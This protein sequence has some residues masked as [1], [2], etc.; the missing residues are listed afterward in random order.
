[1]LEEELKAL[2]EVRSGA[3][4]SIYMPADEV[5][6]EKRKN[7]I[8]LKNLLRD[9][10]NALLQQDLRPAAA[11]D[12]LKRAQVLVAD[13]AFWRKQSS[14]IAI[15]LNPQWFR[16]YSLPLE[17]K[18]EVVVS[19]RFH[20]KPILP[21]LTADYGFFVLALS[22][23][24]IGFFE[25]TPYDIREIALQNIPLSLDEALKYDDPERQLQFHTGTSGASG[26]D[27]RSAMFH[28]Q[29]DDSKDDI[30]RFFR[31]V[32]KGLQPLLAKEQKPLLLAGVEYLHA[33]YKSAN[34]YSKLLES[35]I[36]GNIDKFS[37][38]QLH[39]KSWNIARVHFRKEREEEFS[40]YRDLRDTR[41]ATGD[42]K[43]IVPASFEGRIDTLFVAAGSRQWGSFDA[44]KRSLMLHSEQEPGD[45][46]LTDFAAAHAYMKGGRVY[47]VKPEEFP[48]PLLCAAIF[49]Y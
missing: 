28:G 29:A 15:F 47:V 6:K 44:E 7:P 9:A 10:E 13:S 11:K 1:M 33:I 42:I 20:I 8:R 24:K 49:R 16:T 22:Q 37:E 32:E 5:G 19:D 3:C 27:Q 43:E 36:T 4:V 12:F 26:K 23:K 2:M 18:T 25:C 35:G 46:D 38:Q 40:R 34:T 45:W 39:E 17:F 41:L 21:L 31:M 14:G 30:L 48:E